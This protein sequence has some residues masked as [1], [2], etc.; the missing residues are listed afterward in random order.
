[1]I[2]LFLIGLDTDLVGFDSEKLVK[3]IA[4][5]DTEVTQ[6]VYILWLQSFTDCG[7]IN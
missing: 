7:P 2:Y 4:M 1:M 5:I 3:E 6:E